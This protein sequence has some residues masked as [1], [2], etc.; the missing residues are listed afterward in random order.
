VI[1]AMLPYIECP[2]CA[3]RGLVRA[4]VD[5]ET[6]LASKDP[7]KRTIWME[8]ERCNGAGILILRETLRGGAPYY[9]APK[10]S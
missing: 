6:R 10:L 4:R 2:G 1:V 9:G 5:E 7:S 8:H 3:G